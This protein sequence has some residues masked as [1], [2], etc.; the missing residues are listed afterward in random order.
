M[1]N[2]PASD[3]ADFLVDQGV[4]TYDTNGSLPLIRVGVEPDIENRVLITLYDTPGVPSNPRY[5]RDQ[6]SIQVRAKAKSEM[7]YPSAYNAQQSVKDTI[8]GMDRRT[9]NGSL[10]VGVWMKADIAS[11]ASDYNKRSIL[12]SSYRMVREYDTTNRMKIE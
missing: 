11:L 9:I 7:D 6:P 1:P 12:V 8:L 10:Y 2:S 5:Q 4:G 3:I